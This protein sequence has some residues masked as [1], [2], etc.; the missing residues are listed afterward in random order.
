MQKIS[1]ELNKN[2]TLIENIFKDNPN[3]IAKELTIF[4]KSACIYFMEGLIDATYLADYVLKPCLK[5]KDENFD[6]LN[7]E[8]NKSN[9]KATKNNLSN[10]KTQINKSSKSSNIIDYILK[11]ILIIG[12]LEVNDDLD[13]LVKEITKGKGIMFVDTCS[14][15]IIL[16]LEKVQQRAITEPPTSAVAKGP[17]AGFVESIKT[18]ISCIRKI[19]ATNNLKIETTNVGKYSNTMIAVMYIEGIADKKIVNAI[20][21]KIKKIN[22]DGIIDSYYVASFLEEHK[23]S[24]FREVGQSEKPDIVSAKMLEGRVTILVDGSPIALT[25]PFMLFEDLQS[26]NDYYSENS[27]SSF[28]RIL[29]FL[30]ILI[31]IALPGVY[32]AIQLHHYKAFPLKFLVT[33]INTTQDLPLTPFLE[34]LLVLILFEI[35]YEASL[36]MP[37]YMGIAMSIVGALILGDTAVK[38]GLVSPPSVMIV[39]V[40]GITLYTVPDQSEQ[41]SILRFVFTVV[42]GIL[43]IYGMVLFGLYLLI[44][45]NDFDSYGVSYLSPYAPYYEEDTKDGIFQRDLLMM[46][47]RPKSLHNKNKTRIRRWKKC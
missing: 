30:S 28:V 5:Y 41:I 10:L 36:R 12:K 43:G 37:K 13:A 45:L 9:K 27:H 44:Y 7:K 29:R 2:K 18:N 38:A 1:K 40:S 3:F 34:M 11:N 23:Y 8:I 33:I 25:L 31:T 39:A 32:I 42:G 19:L 14:K 35:L 4:G 6:A 20:M 46:R 17:R 24:I 26:S 16:D 47:K 21:E 15:Y 22:I